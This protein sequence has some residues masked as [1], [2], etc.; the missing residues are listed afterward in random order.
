MAE[1]VVLPANTTRSEFIKSEQ[2]KEQKLNLFVRIC[3]FG[4][5][6]GATIAIAW[7]PATV[8]FGRQIIEL[9][10]PE[11]IQPIV[12]GELIGGFLI[13]AICILCK[14]GLE[15]KATAAKNRV[16]VLQNP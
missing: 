15:K 8:F 14:K 10:P 3:E 13:S 9:M 2:A 7:I 12:Q 5:K 16:S 4:N 6:V 11:K 1:R